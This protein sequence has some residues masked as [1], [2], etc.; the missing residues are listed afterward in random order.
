MPFV[1]GDDFLYA[2]KFPNQGFVGSSTIENVSDYF[3]SQ[4]NH[5]N[6]YNNRIAPHALLQILLLL[7]FYFFDIINVIV[8]LVLPWLVIEPIVNKNNHLN[9]FSGFSKYKFLYFTMLLFLWCFHYDLGRSYL[10][11]TGSVNYSWYLVLQLIYVGQLYKSIFGN[12]KFKFSSILLAI[13]ICTSN[14]NIVLSLFLA[15]LFAWGYKKFLKKEPPENFIFCSAL[16]LLLG[17]LLMLNSPALALRIENESV[18]FGSFSMKI[19]E[20]FKRQAYYGLCAFS[21]VLFLLSYRFKSI[22]KLNLLFFG[23]LILYSS[24]V[25]FMAPLYEPRSSIFSFF[26]FLMFV[27]SCL[28]LEVFKNNYLIIIL[29]IITVCLINSR[30]N[31][32]NIIR[33]SYDENFKKIKT[34]KNNQDIQ[35]SK[36]CSDYITSAVVCDDLSYDENKFENKILS[37]Y[38]DK[39]TVRLKEDEEKRLKDIFEM[40]FKSVTKGSGGYT[41]KK[42][43]EVLVDNYFLT[44]VYKNKKEVIFEVETISTTI[45]TE[46]ISYTLRGV[47]RN[48]W[49]HK[50]LKILPSV[51][52]KYFLHYLETS[53]V[54]FDTDR[55]L[56]HSVLNVEEYDEFIFSLYDK[57][58]HNSIGEDVII[59]I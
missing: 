59:S 38:L 11:T 41:Y 52:S 35:L 40:N 23:I 37:A 2:L 44:G 39:R 45:E 6:N 25:M 54:Y 26:I 16:I 10:W 18:E 8:F 58:N 29:L 5:Y 22:N 46:H 48:Q 12:Y 42:Y 24:L 21:S 57:R 30:T 15:T 47:K 4:V 50:F 43:D 33:N 32:V 19:L 49:R 53:S 34:L 7:P 9:F 20:Y 3:T 31:E 13:L 28:N 27:L 17:G 55:I 56:F 14:E 36:F 51:V 1:L